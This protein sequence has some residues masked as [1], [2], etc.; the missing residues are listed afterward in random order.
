MEYYTYDA[1]VM[2]MQVRSKPS[3]TLKIFVPQRAYSLGC[4]YWP[5]GV[6]NLG[7]GINQMLYH[8]LYVVF[9]I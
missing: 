5:P 2:L 9:Q 6:D 8:K 3:A 4:G 7:Y 1:A